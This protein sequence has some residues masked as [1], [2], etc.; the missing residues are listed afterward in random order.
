MTR[1]DT[2]PALTRTA[3]AAMA[4]LRGF[5]VDGVSGLVATVTLTSFE[6]ASAVP[7]AFD[8][9]TRQRSV[10]PTSDAAGRLTHRGDRGPAAPGRVGR[11]A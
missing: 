11:M 4:G 6:S 10:R 9:V 1:T 7:L 2:A 8:A 3:A 5:G